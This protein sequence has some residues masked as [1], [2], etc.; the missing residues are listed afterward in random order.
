MT[1]EQAKA[2]AAAAQRDGIQL[3]IIA[4]YVDQNLVLTTAVVGP[5]CDVEKYAAIAGVDSD[6]F[7]WNYQSDP[8]A[9]H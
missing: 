9:A 1:L 4:S 6:R 2:I 5:P 3:R 7:E 8:P